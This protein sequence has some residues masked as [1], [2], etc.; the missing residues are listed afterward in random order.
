[1]NR[2]TC[3]SYH[4]L[5]WTRSLT[6]FS[7]SNAHP[8]QAA[9]N[10]LRVAFALNCFPGMSKKRS[11]F[12]NGFDIPAKALQTIETFS[13]KLPGWEFRLLP[14]RQQLFQ[15]VFQFFNPGHELQHDTYT[16][17]VYSQM[18]AQPNDLSNQGHHFNTKYELSIRIATAG[19]YEAKIDESLDQL[20]VNATA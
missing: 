16:G 18:I 14:V 6:S 5:K 3:P 19:V 2:A 9:K 10:W 1:M 13:D 8:K 11:L 20:R 15:P 7:T 4:A 12:E 17:L